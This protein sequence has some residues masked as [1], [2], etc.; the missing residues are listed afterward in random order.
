VVTWLASQPK[1]LEFQPQ[2][3]CGSSPI[4]H[5]LAGLYLMSF[6]AVLIPPLDTAPF[7]KGFQVCLTNH[8]TTTSE[9]RKRALTYQTYDEISRQSLFLTKRGF[10]LCWDVRLELGGSYCWHEN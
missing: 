3:P 1:N 7:E 4:T 5:Y 6:L 9:D 8:V 2:V 10:S